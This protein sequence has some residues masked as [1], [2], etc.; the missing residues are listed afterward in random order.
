VSLVLG[1]SLLL[2]QTLVDPAWAAEEAAY[3]EAVANGANRYQAAGL[4]GFL[5]A[6]FTVAGLTGVLHL[7]RSRRV[8][9][10]QVGTVLLMFGVIGGGGAYIANLIEASAANPAFDRGQMAAMLDGAVDSPWVVPVFVVW[11]GGLG[12]GPVLLAIGLFLRRAA[13][14][15]WVPI[16]L[17]AGTVVTFVGVG[18]SQLVAA[19]GSLLVVAACAGLAAKILTTS[20][21]Q[22][23]RWQVLPD[24]RSARATSPE[25]PS[26][27]VGPAPV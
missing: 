21:E 16:V 1:P 8:N 5:G 22:W 24:E 3:L 12:L 20:D 7:V 25:R 13:A 2:A 17:I 18:S 19:L 14:P 15:I 4:L 11:I 26:D 9:L 27:S 10:A 23:G 6:L